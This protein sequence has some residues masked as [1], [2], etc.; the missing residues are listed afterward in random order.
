MLI[1]IVPFAYPLFYFP[2]PRISLR[3]PPRAAAACAKGPCASS[4]RI[5]MIDPANADFVRRQ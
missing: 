2:K 1:S 5:N 4:D 3:Y